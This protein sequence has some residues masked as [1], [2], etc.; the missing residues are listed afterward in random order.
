VADGRLWHAGGATDEQELAVALATFVALLRMTGAVGR[1]DV[2]LAADTDQ[3]RTIAKF[4][5]MRLLLA[6]IGEIANLAK[7]PRVHAETAWRAMSAVDPETNILRA[8]SGAFGAA[9]GGADSITVLPFDLLTANDA[10]GRRLARNTQIILA[11]EANIFRVA[12]PAAGSGAIETMTAA[13]AAAAWRRFQAIEAQGGV[14]EA[15]GRGPLL[16]EVAEAREARLTLAANG[17]IRMIG[18]NAY[19]SNDMP[20]TE[21]ARRGPVEKSERLAFKRLSEYFETAA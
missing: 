11:D 19:A 7:L 10:H 15:I 6:R 9:I 20:T 18:V 21:R 4:R 17:T 8:T 13:L 3:F 14:V 2:V 12:D 1:V 16:R 5:A